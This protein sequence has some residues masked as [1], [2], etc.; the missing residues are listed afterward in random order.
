M[1]KQR[2]QIRTSKPAAAV[3]PVSHRQ[4]LPSGS[5]RDRNRIEEDGEMAMKRLIMI[6]G[7]MA[8]LSASPAFAQSYD[9]DVGSGNVLNVPAAE[10]AGGTNTNAATNSYAFAP[11]RTSPRPVHTRAQT[12]N[13]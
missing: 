8:A 4:Q 3:P 12:S 9:A 2:K 1:A 5:L 10:R 6:A 13:E 11:A 7:T